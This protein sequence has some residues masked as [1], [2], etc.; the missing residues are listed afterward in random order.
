MTEFHTGNA[1]FRWTDTFL[2]TLQTFGVEHVI[3]SPGSRSTPL[4]LA[5]ATNDGLQKHVILDE[6][7]AAFTA[8]GIGKATN[9]P[10][11]L[12]CTSGTALANYY[13]AVIEA[14]Q[15]GV[16][17]I[18]ATADRPPHLRATGANQA[19]D[20]QKIFG[21]YPVF[22]HDVGE[23]TTANQDLKRLSMLGQQSVTLARE[24]R[25]PVHL[26]FPFRK[27]LEPEPQWLNTYQPEGSSLEQADTNLT[28]FT[29]SEEVQQN[30]STAKRP[31]IM[32]G[33][34]A[35]QDHTKSI[36]QLASRLGCPILA[37]PSIDHKNTIPGFAGFLRSQA[38]RN[39]LEP[40]LILRFGFQP[41]S[42]SLE[43]GLNEWEPK[44]H[45]HFASTHA[46]QDATYSGA[47]HI[48]WMGK[49]LHFEQLSPSPNSKWL[50]QW[51]AAEQ[52][53]R[54]FRNNV[55]E[56][57]SELTDGAIYDHITPQLNNEQFMMVSNSFPARDINLFGR[58]QPRTPLYL[59][60]GVSGIDGITSTAI[61]LSLALDQPGVLVTGDLAFLHDTNALLNS[62]NVT[63]PLTI[64]II[65][66][67]GG[68]I[69]RMLPVEQHKQ[70]FRDYFETPQTANIQ[71]MAGSYDIPY[72]GIDTLDELEQLSLPSW[73]S[74]HYSLSI[75]E[76]QTD[77]D[78]SMEQR[79]KLWD[80]SV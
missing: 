27:P 1:A 73:M 68:S 40:D 16:P 24:K 80:Y 15:S 43:W 25:G 3:I 50:K 11:V 67:S 38:A 22:Y 35:P 17:L 77:A 53:F 57:Q 69:F 29:L 44:H 19:I 34:L 54:A 42:K 4:T 56:A 8:L 76:C 33:P 66:N 28:S 55:M 5:A 13:P 45:Y 78:A 7:S 74:K 49:A 62:D 39:T 46:W 6:R 41:T 14:R 2:R 10:A 79:Q 18:L 21:D 61:G 58:H 47:T 12:I 23:P 60:R 37:E 31:L 52:S 70:Y 51:R 9:A 75:I 63:Q 65:N 26:N 72:L 71:Q 20:Q 64:I 30:I 32:V 36:G 59:N 48:P